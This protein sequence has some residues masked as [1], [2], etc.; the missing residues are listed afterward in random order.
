MV[1]VATPISP[2]VASLGQALLVAAVPPR[3]RGD[4][5]ATDAVPACAAT[6]STQAC[7][8]PTAAD[9][10]ADLAKTT[11]Y[12]KHSAFVSVGAFLGTATLAPPL[13]KPTPITPQSLWI[14]SAER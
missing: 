9:L 14:T 5:V 3:L 6:T 4:V 12:N 13:T 1:A 10:L 7:H 11:R 2:P 8:K